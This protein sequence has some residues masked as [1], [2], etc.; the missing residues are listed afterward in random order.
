MMGGILTKKQA[1]DFKILM[2]WDSYV[3]ENNNPEDIKLTLLDSGFK[4]N[5][6]NESGDTGK[7]NK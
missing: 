7:V 2:K 1:A 5:V 6:M 4:R 3:E